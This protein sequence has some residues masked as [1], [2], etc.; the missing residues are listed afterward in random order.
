MS[1]LRT[2]RIFRTLALSIIAAGMTQ[3][4][5]INVAEGTITVTDVV[6]PIGPLFQYDYTIA[7][8]TGQLAVLD[9]AV[10]PGITISG[11]TGPGG[12]ADFETAYD[13]VLGLVSFVENNSVFS[14]TPESGFIFDTSVPPGA[15]TF[16]VTL[17]D[18]TT[19]SGSVEGPVVP[20]PST[21]P[22]CALGGAALLF[23]RK[24][25]LASRTL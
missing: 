3:A 11:L 19:G 18:G 12:P 9:I 7:D 1:T 6:T 8:G 10:T 16:D 13:S 21:L 4:G 5:I 14:A 2:V 24:R 23:W 25:L 15:S 17:F 20:E 22:L